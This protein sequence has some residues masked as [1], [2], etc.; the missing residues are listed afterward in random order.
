MKQSR[1]IKTKR[2]K[3]FAREWSYPPTRK[4]RMYNLSR[5]ITEKEL[6]VFIDNCLQWC[7]QLFGTAKDKEVPY[8]EWDWKSTWY[9]KRNLLAVYDREDNEIYIRIQGHR[10]IYNLANTIIHEYIHYLQPSS[11][12]WYER[13]DKKW[14]YDKNPYE[15]EA[16]LLGDLYAVEC[17]QT[18]L[19][20]MGKG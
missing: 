15:I 19:S 7:E 11:G 17:A 5:K 13:Y 12:G 3:P 8:V 4:V 2:L 18:S 9:Q 1:M 10:T 6:N 14:G 20:K 16:K